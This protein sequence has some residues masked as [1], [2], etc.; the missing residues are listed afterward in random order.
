VKQKRIQECDKGCPMTKGN[1]IEFVLAGTIPICGIISAALFRFSHDYS[2]IFFVLLTII[3][4]LF[5]VFS[6]IKNHRLLE[7]PTIIQD[8]PIVYSPK[9]TLTVKLPKPPDKTHAPPQY[10]KIPTKQEP[11]ELSPNHIEILKVFRTNDGELTSVPLIEQHTGLE[12]IVINSALDDFE[13]HNLINATNLDDFNGGWQYQL[14][15]KGRK[16][17]LKFT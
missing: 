2:A 11:L 13:K 17:A 5:W 4:A 8:N 16:T 3:S 10:K 7:K 6:R 15:E 12:S 14:T 1:K 9:N